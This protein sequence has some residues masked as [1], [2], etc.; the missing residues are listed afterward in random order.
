MTDEEKLAVLF[1]HA[2]HAEEALHILRYFKNDQYDPDLENWTVEPSMLSD[3]HNTYFRG[4]IGNHRPWH[5][6]VHN[7]IPEIGMNYQIGV[8]K[9]DRKRGF[10]L[11]NLITL[12]ER[13]I[14]HANLENNSDTVIAVHV[15]AFFIYPE[16]LE[17]K[18]TLVSVPLDLLVGLTDAASEAG[19]PIA[20]DGYELIRKHQ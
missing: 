5:I 6:S 7:H 17:N 9:Y 15:M 2:D 12:E 18:E 11:W 8:I 4:E 19:Y 13:I 1:K 14:T 10:V 3:R 20:G 16:L